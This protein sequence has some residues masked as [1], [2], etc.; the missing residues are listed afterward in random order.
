MSKALEPIIQ[1]NVYDALCIKQDKV[2]LNRDKTA[3]GKE[4]DLK[5]GENDKYWEKGQMISKAK[6]PRSYW[7]KQH[8]YN[9][10]VRR[11]S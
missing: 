10:S 6:E 7:V 9:V 4:I 3:R 11:N 5:K 2:K 1:A 8:G